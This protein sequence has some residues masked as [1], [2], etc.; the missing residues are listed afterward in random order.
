MNFIDINQKRYKNC[1]FTINEELKFKELYEQ[2]WHISKIAKEFNMSLMGIHRILLAHKTKIRSHGEGT[3]LL[4]EH[5]KVK[6]P[7]DFS[8]HLKTKFDKLLASFLLTDGHLNTKTKRVM[9]ICTDN[10]LQRYFLTLIKERYNFFPTSKSFMFKGKETSVYS[11]E[12]TEELLKLSPSYNTYPRNVSVEEYF[13]R[14]QPTL[15]FLNN[16]KEELLK[17]FIRIAMSCEGCVFP[18]FARDILYVQLQFACSHPKLVEEWQEL[19]Q[20]MGI[21]SFILKSKVTWSRVKG[22]GIKELKSIKRFIEIGGFIE[23]VKI[24]GKS[25]YF[26]GIE[27]NDLLKILFEMKI[28]NFRFVKN[29]TNEEKNKII[30]NSCKTNQNK[31]KFL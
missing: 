16:E 6:S 28:N 21:K 10:I 1:K 24:T 27:K 5:I 30:L 22:L 8:Y 18:E 15:S 4:H 2:G 20:K 19:F 11:K 12:I 3:R 17:E 31:K 23:G 29:L 14:S 13:K 9:L 25:K 26:K 7:K